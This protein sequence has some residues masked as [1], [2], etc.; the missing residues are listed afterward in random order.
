MSILITGSGLLG[1]HVAKHLIL[2]SYSKIILLDIAPDM[3]YIKNILKENINKIKVI[4]GSILDEIF[5]EKVISK[6]KIDTIIHTAA[7]VSISS[8]IEHF[9]MDP[10][11][12]TQI[13]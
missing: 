5:I 13:F 1:A 10:I 9:K 6:Y 2:D 12:K 4:Q 7:L 3:D 8:D 11:V